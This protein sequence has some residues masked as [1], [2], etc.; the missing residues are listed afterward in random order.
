[1]SLTEGLPFPQY[2][3][4]LQLLLMGFTTISPLLPY[5]VHLPLKALQ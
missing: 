2:N 4:F 5:N 3:T 1:M